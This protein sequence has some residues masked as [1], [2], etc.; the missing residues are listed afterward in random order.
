MEKVR[1]IYQMGLKHG[2]TLAAISGV[3]GVF[4]EADIDRVREL[5]LSAREGKPVARD[6][7]TK[8]GRARKRSSPLAKARVVPALAKAPVSKRKVAA[9]A[10]V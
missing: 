10:K 4:T 3:N 9:R 2:M 5:A 8:A 6:L 7:A 1:E